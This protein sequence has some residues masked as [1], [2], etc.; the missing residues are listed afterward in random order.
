MLPD[1]VRAALIPC[2]CLVGIYA[3]KLCRT[4]AQLG[5]RLVGHEERR[6]KSESFVAAGFSPESISTVIASACCGDVVQL[7]RTLPSRWLESHTVTAISLPHSTKSCGNGVLGRTRL[8]WPWRAP[9][10]VS[11]LRQK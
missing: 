11:A 4:T 5:E 1:K 8:S 10:L 6:N 3:V 9:Q 7:V 2:D